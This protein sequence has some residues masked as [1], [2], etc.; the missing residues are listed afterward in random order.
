MNTKYLAIAVGATLSI[1]SLSPV[2]KA[3]LDPNALTS[4]D[5]K[6]TGTMPQQVESDRR[7]FAPDCG[8]CR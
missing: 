3:I 5:S 6:M 2:A 8:P 1:L 7:V 4:T